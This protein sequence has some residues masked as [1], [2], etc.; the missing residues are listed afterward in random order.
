MPATMTDELLSAIEIET[1]DPPTAAVIWMHGLGDT[2]HGWSE[3][4]P[5]LRLPAA[6]SVRFVFPHAPQIPVTINQG[7]RMPA[8]YDFRDGDF[9]DRADIGGVRRSQAQVEALIAR[10]AARG[11]PGGRVVL[12][13]FSQG[14]A[15]ALYAG[16]RRATPLAAIIAL[17][18][19][20]IA[21]DAVVA[22]ASPANRDIPI[23][24]AHGTQD[25]VVQFRWADASR[26]AL[27]A[28]GFRV[29]WH[30]YP[31]PHSAVPEEIAAIGKFLTGVF[32]R[33]SR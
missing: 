1:G 28:A 21:P 29:E 32:E 16:L 3:V 24:M 9:T 19:Y 18:T 14:G 33:P 15:V 25:P 5:A 17:S 11:I 23:F 12:A 6:L 27:V 22:E 31:M 30:T 7:A 4:V 8:W 26:Q 10:E 13:G 2:G 20:L